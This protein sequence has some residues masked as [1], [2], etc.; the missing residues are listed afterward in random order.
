[1]LEK[2]ETTAICTRITFSK[3]PF[4]IA[5]FKS[6]EY[7]NF[8]LK[9]NMAVKTGCTYKVAGVADHLSNY[10]D[11]YKLTS[12]SVD[13]DM[14]N[15]TKSQ[16][17]NFFKTFMTDNQRDALFKVFS[18]VKDV[19]KILDDNNRQ[20][21]LK[22]KGIGPAT[23]DRI[24]ENYWENKDYSAALVSFSEYGLTSEAVKKVCR[25][26]KGTSNAISILKE[27]P[28]NLIK[29]PGFGFS[30]ADQAFLYNPDNKRDDMRRIKAFIDY[31]F[32]NEYQDGNTWL[33]P[34]DFIHKFIEYL[35]MVK[36]EK[37]IAIVNESPDFLVVHMDDEPEKVRVAAKKNVKLEIDI[38]KELNRLM[39]APSKMQLV[40]INETLEKTQK[41]QGFTFS[42]EQLNA[43]YEMIDKNVYM[44]QGLSGAGKTSSV[45]GFLDIVSDN[46]Y[47]YRQCALSGKAANNLSQVTGKKGETIHYML[48]INSTDAISTLMTDCVVLDELS[49]VSADIFL[50][51][52]K[53]IPSGSKLIMIGDY[54][55]LESIGVGVMGGLIRSKVIP[56]TLLKKIHRQAQ[57]SAIITHS[58]A[59]RQGITPSDLKM[60]AD[61]KIR[62]YGKK[63]DLDYI[64]VK[65]DQE[66]DI[67]KHTLNVFR[68]KLKIYDPSDI[69][70]ICATKKTGKVSVQKINNYA[71]IIANP[72]DD[73]KPEIEVG[74]GDNKYILRRGDRVINSKNNRETTSPDGRPMPIFNGNTGIIKQVLFENESDRNNKE[75][76]LIIDFEGIGEVRVGSKAIN[77]IELGYAITAHKCQGS[78][79]KCVILAM[80]FHFMLNS[81]ELTY[82]AMT[83]TSEHL[84]VI[85]SPKTLHE[86]IRKTS[87]KMRKTNLEHF[88]KN[89]DYWELQLLEKGK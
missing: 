28:Y 24:L 19:L 25:H 15:A 34:A 38:A 53:A 18:E 56:M 64:F 55:Q 13:I 12:I 26:F 36:P 59:I 39:N 68:E 10:P 88:L 11:T 69:Q 73:W 14:N 4:T 61:G 49:M 72:K 62:T 52:L 60:V 20:E 35:P 33:T 71:Q 8:S 40:H 67:L 84:T 74:F 27:N 70:I 5:I 79:I 51:L 89:T 66:E 2:I 46:L 75:A 86:A 32:D 85:T 80:P 42:E 41:E 22:V 65:R 23:A 7:G 54:G 82:T 29:V 47:S 1:M 48:G 16:L 76:Y 77:S 44:L 78:T 31:L 58:I 30:K 45:K 43:I 37:G 21:L 9:G 50:K 6:K 3:P 63:Q 81:K 83:R 57:D 17:K 87:T